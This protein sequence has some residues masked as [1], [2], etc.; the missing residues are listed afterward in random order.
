[1]G[2]TITYSPSDN[3]GGAGQGGGWTSRWSYEPEW[4]IGMNSIFYSF[5]NGDIYKH[6]SNASRNQF[7]GVNY[8]S[9][10]TP[11]FNDNPIEAKMFLT[12]ELEGTDAWEA[13]VVT[14]LT[15]GFIDKDYFV[16]KEGVYYSNIRR[17]FNDDDLSQTSAQGIGQASN[18]TGVAPV[19]IEFTQPISGLLSVGDTA[20]IGTP[21]GITEIGEVSS[22]VNGVFP[23]PSSITVDVPV[24]IPIIGD[25]IMFLKNSEVESYGSRGYYA[26]VTLTNN[27][28]TESEL[29]AVSAE[30]FKSFP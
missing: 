2:D 25:F 26:E 14:D 24:N 1:M 15:E 27:L 3:R 8:P 28:T 18:V 5:K 30:V 7:Y 17:Y 19:V 11:V 12:L 20:Y 6:Y 16:K 29:F 22:Y 4:M 13:A 21:G 9:T 23:L 10:V